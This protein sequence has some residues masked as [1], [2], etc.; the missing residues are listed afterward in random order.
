MHTAQEIE[1]NHILF[2]DDDAISRRFVEK[3]L[4]S[5]IPGVHVTCAGDGAQALAV[6]D[7]EPVDLLITDLA[8]P[9]IDGIDLL[10]QVAR[11]RLRIPLLVVTGHAT[12]STE[13]QALSGGAIDRLSQFTGISRK[14][15]ERCVQLKK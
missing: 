6:L 7:R 3:M 8:M 1:Q 9:V 11:R 4:R 5:S 10:L 12:P 14:L 2:V 15:I 13:S